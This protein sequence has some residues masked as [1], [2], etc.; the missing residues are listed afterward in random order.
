[1]ILRFLGLPLPVAMAIS[2]IST[3]GCGQRAPSATSMPE[4]AIPQVV[5]DRPQRK[6]LRLTTTQPGQI[7]AFEQTPLFAKVSG[8]VEAV[9]VD[10]GDAVKK[11]QTL[12]KLSIPEMLDDLT[13]KEAMIAQTEAEAKQA[14]SMIQASEAAAETAHAKIAEAEA[15][16]GRA[17][18]ELERWKSE[19]ARMK[20]LTATGSVTKRL[21]DETL[22]QFHAAEASTREAA[23]K[24]KSARAAY[25]EAKA[26]V[27]K[28]KADRE[29]FA[30]RLNVAK[31][32]LARTKTMTGYL[33]IKAPY[34]GTITRRLVDT[35]QYV[36]PANGNTHQSLMTIAR[37]D[38]VRIFVDV[39]ELEAGRVDAGDQATIRVQA[40]ESK[41]F[42][43]K[44]TR[45]SWSLLD[46]NHSLR[47][48]IDLPNPQGTLRPGMYATAT[49]LLGE[50]K[51]V[52]TLP[53]TA[54]VREG[55]DA[56]CMCVESDHLKRKP[57]ELGLR[58]GGEFEIVSGL[59]GTEM[60]VLKQPEVFPS[61]QQV[62][63]A[64]PTK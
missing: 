18:A 21:E 49:I 35:G 51:D 13:Q 28:A 30:A 46:T 60:V 43:A 26:N 24:V 45:T 17:N 14:E 47:A 55:Q 62:L 38:V 15:G 54:I 5:A 12:I 20:E 22:N 7:A 10:I 9:L 36:Y 63:V 40:V 19:H 42:E 32:D 2:M 27:L 53:M 29:A 23:A 6:T 33:E 8:Y 4:A 39:P 64:S 58:S 48:E 1:M 37:S 44:V 59:T 25:A 61:G 56:Y 34:D 11:G 41:P 31:A 16:I 3:C 50:R 52:I 57:I